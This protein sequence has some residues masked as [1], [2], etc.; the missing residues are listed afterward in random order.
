MDTKDVVIAYP[1][2]EGPTTVSADW[3]FAL[4]AND[5]GNYRARIHIAILDLP[6][7][8]FAEIGKIVVLP[9]SRISSASSWAM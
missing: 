1:E 8:I 2:P 7:D 9:K 6:A 3:A 5:F 4:T